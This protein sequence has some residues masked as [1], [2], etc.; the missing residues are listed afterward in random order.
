MLRTVEQKKKPLDKEKVFTKLK[1][2]KKKIK[3]MKVQLK[4]RNMHANK[5]EQ[6]ISEKKWIKINNDVR[7]GVMSK[8]SIFRFNLLIIQA[9]HINARY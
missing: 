5:I 9:T 1:S 6:K 3:E 8:I 7:H 2:S 4:M